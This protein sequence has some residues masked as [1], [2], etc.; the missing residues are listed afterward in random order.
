[1]LAPGPPL[2]ARWQ[3]IPRPSAPASQVNRYGVDTEGITPVEESLSEHLVQPPVDAR[4]GIEDSF[5]L[6]ETPTDNQIR[7][8]VT[9]VRRAFS[10]V[11]ADPDL[12]GTPI[13]CRLSTSGR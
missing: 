10:Q 9:A 12:G 6:D 7:H 3:G 13:R 8:P 1:M 11:Q 5:D 4:S 2:R